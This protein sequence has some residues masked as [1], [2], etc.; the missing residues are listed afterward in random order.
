MIY[1]YNKKNV[2][3]LTKAIESW[4]N[5]FLLLT[6]KSL[7]VQGQCCKLWLKYTPKDDDNTSLPRSCGGNQS[8]TSLETISFCETK[9]PGGVVLCRPVWALWYLV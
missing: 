8:F 6:Y 3:S 5:D 1:N 4:E 2:K 9:P 7:I